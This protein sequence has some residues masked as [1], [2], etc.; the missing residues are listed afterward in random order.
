M[1]E[2]DVLGVVTGLVRRRLHCAA[3]LCASTVGIAQAPVEP[4]GWLDGS[5]S[6]L[7]GRAVTPTIDIDD[8]GII[9]IAIGVPV[10][11]DGASQVGGVMFVSGRNLSV[12]ELVRGPPGVMGYGIGVCEAPDLDADGSDELLVAGYRGPWAAYSP[13]KRSIVKQFST[14]GEFGGGVG[15]WDRDETLDFVVNGAIVSGATGE[16]IGRIDPRHCVLAAYRADLLGAFN[17][18]PLELTDSYSIAWSGM[19]GRQSHCLV[20]GAT[21]P[22]KP[23]SQVGVA[24]FN[25]DGRL[26]VVV[27]D[28]SDDDRQSVLTMSHKPQGSR[29]DIYGAVTDLQVIPDIDNDCIPDVVVGTY[30]LFDGH[31]TAFSGQSLHA[32]WGVMCGNG[33]VS[34][35][36]LPDLNADGF[37]EICVGSG[38]WDRN[39]AIVKPDGQVSIVSSRDGKVFAALTEEQVDPV[40]RPPR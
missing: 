40:L 5:A 33:N 28:R 39:N 25:R 14:T 30:S 35:G 18:S 26:D 24:D 15:D 11:A 2:T 12:L 29:K 10:M 27:A 37:P 22:W 6:S 17:R 8:D 34:L 31:A 3:Y 4:P 7:W 38:H 20:V 21:V 13:I 19:A 23:Y 16:S 9:D 1:R 36:L 32:I